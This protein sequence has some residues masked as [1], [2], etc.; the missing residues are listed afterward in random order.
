VLG[1][2]VALV[3]LTA[4]VSFADTTV[5]GPQTYT[6]TPWRIPFLTR[7]VVSHFQVQQPTGWFT[8]RVINHGVTGAVISLNGQVVNLYDA[9]VTLREV[10]VAA[11]VGPVRLHAGSNTLAVKIQGRRGASLTLEIMQDTTPPTMTAVPTPPANAQGW[12]NSPVVVTFSATDAGSGMT[13]LPVPVTITTEGAGQIVKGTATDFAGNRAK[14]TTVVSLDMTPPEFVMTSP[15]SGAI[16]STSVLTL[17]GTLTDLLS[18]VAS[19]TCNGAMGTVH[20]DNTFSCPLTLEEG[21]NTLPLSATD[22]AGNTHQ[23]LVSLTRQ[24]PAPSCPNLVQDPGFE[25]GVSG[26]VKQDAPSQVT[27]TNTLPLEGSSSLLVAINRW[28]DNVWWD[29]GFDGR[30]SRFHTSMHLRSD[31]P[32]ASVLKFCAAIYYADDPG[33]IVENCINVSGAMGDK[34]MVSTGLDLDSTRTLDSVHIRLYQEG[35]APVQFTI[36]SAVACLDGVSDPGSSTGADAGG[37]T[38]TG[39]SGAGGGTGSGSGGGSANGGT[40]P[41]VPAR[42]VNRAPAPPAPATTA[43]PFANGVTVRLQRILS[44]GDVVSFGVPIPPGVN[45]TEVSSTRVLQAGVALDASVREILALHDD[46]GVRTGIRAVQIQFDASFMSGDEMDV[47]V[48]WRSTTGNAPGTTMVPYGEDRVSSASDEAVDTAVRTITSVGGVNALVETSKARVTL[49]TAREPHVL[50]TFPDGYLASTGILGQ[51]MTRAEVADLPE[52]AGLSFLSDAMLAF[53]LSSMYAE[54]Y[55]L[56]PESVVDPVANFEGW[57]Y[58]RCATYLTAYVHTT[59]VRFLREAYRTCWY[60]ASKINLTGPDAGIFSGKPYPDT[61]YSHLRGL[62]AYY[63]LS[64]DELALQAGTAIAAMWYAEP[65]FVLPYRAG[66]TRG[67]DRLWTERLL[68]TSLE[69][70]YYG[71]RLTGDPQYLYAF[72]EMFETAYRHITGDAATLAEI[73]PDIPVSFPP[74]NC[75]IHTAEQHTEGNGD[76]PWCS[77][78]MSEL[79]VDALLRYEGQTGDARTGEIFIRLARFLRDVGSAYFTNNLLDDSFLHPSVPYN[80]A[81]GENARRLVP[82][83]GA[84]LGPDLVRQNFGEYDDFQHCTD[85]TALTAAALWA[86][87]IQGSYDRNPIGPFASEGAS[88]LQLH[89]EFAACAARTFEEQ[90]RSRRDP[91]QWLSAELAPGLGDPATF[92]RQNKIGYPVGNLTPQRKFSWWFNMSMLQFGLLTEAGITVPVLTPGLIQP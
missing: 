2:L 40:E 44:G 78:W 90:T 77:I 42:C 27:Q 31:V 41:A 5:F 89:H 60:Y 19:V 43:G 71:H 59:D 65:L 84:G 53:G 52:L 28:G 13:H 91:R 75:F 82:L 17:T 21:L 57:L 36:D 34:G 86:L 3:V 1:L 11:L 72:V 35:S 56:H 10:A 76:Q 48:V 70:L 6:V 68:G 15:A 37:G 55:A 39:G 85:A 81:D 38:A 14:A 73:N 24:T 79:M 8:L 22:V 46:C 66:H 50:A 62:Y 61:K 26:F 4:R 7:A 23:Q 18:G 45:L 33:T 67:P 9:T 20:P 83:Y 80:P 87:E 69:G 32:S 30:A 63:A 25:A 58:D 64:G 12:H 47:D 16:V 92:I 49:F 54:E 74:Q 51:Q 29:Y 88:F